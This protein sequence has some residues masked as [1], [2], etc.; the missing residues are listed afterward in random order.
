[1]DFFFL[2]LPMSNTDIDVAHSTI[3]KDQM[4]ER[5][6]NNL[7]MP[8][9]FPTNQKQSYLSLFS[10]W[11]HSM[12]L[13]ASRSYTVISAACGD[14]HPRGINAYQPSGSHPHFS[15]SLVRL[16]LPSCFLASGVTQPCDP[17]HI[18]F[19]NRPWS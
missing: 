10:S 11:F 7:R 17:A 6:R 15:F 4:R 8:M 9:N 1:M 14:V 16:P 19:P 18:A 12:T 2:T 13:I 3:I 5:T